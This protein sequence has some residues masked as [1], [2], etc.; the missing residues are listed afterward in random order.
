M[1]SEALKKMQ[2]KIS[3]IASSHVSSRVLQVIMLTT[4]CSLAYSLQVA[5]YYFISK[6]ASSSHLWASII[7]LFELQTCVKHCTQDE[8]N[9]VFMEIRPHFVFLASN[10]YAVRFVTKMLDHGM[11]LAWKNTS[12]SDF[13]E[14]FCFSFSLPC[15]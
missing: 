3:E 13:R 5:P 15:S 1:V 2:G 8:R 9:A 14:R 10:P 6:F 4:S 11:I 12:Q 7:C